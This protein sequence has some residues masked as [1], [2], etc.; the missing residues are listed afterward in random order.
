[1][2]HFNL[3]KFMRTT[4][5]FIIFLCNFGITAQ[6][7]KIEITA[8]KEIGLEGSAA[9]FEVGFKVISGKIEGTG[10]YDPLAFPL[11]NGTKAFAYLNSYDEVVA[12]KTAPSPAL[13]KVYGAKVQVGKI[14]VSHDLAMVKTPVNRS[15]EFKSGVAFLG[16]E[17]KVFFGSIGNIKGFAKIGDE[18]AYTN[19]RG[20]RGKGKI[21]GFEVEGGSQTDVIFEGVPDNIVNIQV[22]GL[23]NVDFSDAKVTPANAGSEVTT[24]VSISANGTKAPNHKSKTIPIGAILENKEVKIT[25]HNLVK[26]NPDSSTRY[27]DVFKVDYTLD[28]YIVDASFENKTDHDL[29]I[30]EYVLRLNFFTA[31]GKSADDFLRVFRQKTDSNNQVKKDA[32]KID[33]NIFGGTSKLAIAGAMVKYE[34]SIPDYDAKHK[35]VTNALNKPLGSGKKIR[36]INAS[37]M[38]VPPEYKIEGLGTW[39]GTFF[40][41][42]HLIFV[43]IKIG[44]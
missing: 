6:N 16:S 26:F 3:P 19:A 14:L 11:P 2:F 41:K 34:E 4:L 28:Y 7:I 22:L 32:D 20:Q 42:K 30:G 13:L 36:S 38:G 44:N 39:S 17:P 25:V 10:R 35:A 37:I 8:C 24:S 33:S 23:D 31:D 43:P 27:S 40:E 1:M 12:G 21:L 5:I 18:I 29:D 9:I 15:F